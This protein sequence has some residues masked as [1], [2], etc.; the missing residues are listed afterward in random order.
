MTRIGNPS[1]L[2]IALCAAGLAG[3]TTTPTYTSDNKYTYCSSHKEDPGCGG[4]VQS[5]AASEAPASPAPQ[6]QPAEQAQPTPPANRG[7]TVA[8]S[9]AEPSGAQAGQCF[10]RVLYPAKF[11]DEEVQEIVRPAYEKVSYTDPVYEDVQ[12]QVLVREAYTRVVEVPALYDTYYEQVVEKPAAKVWKKGRGA[13]ER[14]DPQTGEI[15]CLVDQPAVFK[16]VEK[17]N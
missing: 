9:C 4:T 2:F 3:C 6:R 8:V 16:T 11:K 14:V 1:I 5:M 12:E 17:K 10:T 13:S 15:Y 7:N